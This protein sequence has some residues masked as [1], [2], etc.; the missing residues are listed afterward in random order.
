M[1]GTST[2]SPPGI[3]TSSSSLLQGSSKNH[4]IVEGVVCGLAL[5]VVVGAGLWI[6]LRKR[7]A[8]QVNAGAPMFEYAHRIP[9]LEHYVRLLAFRPVSALTNIPRTQLALSHS[10]TLTIVEVSRSPAR[11]PIGPLPRLCGIHVKIGQGLIF[12]VGSGTSF[13]VRS[14]LPGVSVC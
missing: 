3:S 6:F 7:A 2:G 4:A 12:T 1:S 8:A 11:S 5:L 9:Q 13:E 10:L 14:Q